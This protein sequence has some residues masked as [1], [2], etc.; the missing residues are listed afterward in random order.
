MVPTKQAA[1]EFLACKR[2]AVTGVSRNP[3]GHG[4]N[5]VLQ[6]LR[7]R[8]YDVVAINPN[9]D[10]ID[11]TPCYHR[12]Q[13]VPSPVEA[14]VIGTRPEHADATMRD[15]VELGIRKVWMHRAFGEGSVDD[16]ATAY[17]REH[18][19]TVIDGG[20]PLM[21]DPTADPFHKVLKLCCGKKVRKQV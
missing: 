21:F 17:G 8:G 15:V 14:V 2:I 1:T 13:D 11:G 12:L 7:Q 20:C 16:A 6:R 5:A 10:E 3:K 19:V 18:G 9:A 4:S